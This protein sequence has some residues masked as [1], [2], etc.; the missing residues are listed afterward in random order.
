[1]NHRVTSLHLFWTSASCMLGTPTLTIW[2]EEGWE[3]A[4]P[5]PREHSARSSELSLSSGLS[6]LPRPVGD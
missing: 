6:S 5:G 4:E 2:G 3:R 1:M